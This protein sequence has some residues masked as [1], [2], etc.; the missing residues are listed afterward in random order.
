MVLDIEAARRKNLAEKPFERMLS[1][2][3]AKL[4]TLEDFLKRSHI[5]TELYHTRAVGLQLPQLR[6]ESGEGVITFLKLLGER[7]LAGL[8]AGG[9]GVRLLALTFTDSLQLTLKK[10]D[11]GALADDLLSGGGTSFCLH[12]YQ[13]Q[14]HKHQY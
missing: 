14:Q 2:L 4:G 8:E 9:E 7:L 5:R 11:R 1:N 13:R 3:P 6:V 12:D 10:V